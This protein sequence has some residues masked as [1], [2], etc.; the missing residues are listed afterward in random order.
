MDS[1][2]HHP[3]ISPLWLFVKAHPALWFFLFVGVVVLWLLN[4]LASLIPQIDVLRSKILLPIAKRWKQKKL[5]KSAI[6][7]DIRGHVNREV[8]KMK[9]YLPLDWI[10]EMDVDWVEAEGS[11]AQSNENK[12]VIRIRPVEDQDRNFANATYYYLRSCFFP[13]TQ[14][15]VPKAHYEA[16][17]L[18][19]CKKII[20]QRSQAALAFFEDSILE[21]SIQRHSSIPNH[22]DDYDRLDRRGFFTGTFL[23]ELHLMAVDARFT[24]ARNSMAQETALV[25]KHIKDFVS[26][27]DAYAVDKQEM[28]QSAWCNDEALSKYAILLVANPAKTGNGIDPYLN[29][30]RSRFESGS[31]RLYVFGS[32]KE[33]RFANSVIA[34]IEGTIDN[35]RL[36]ERFETPF[37][38]RGDKDGVGA[39]FEYKT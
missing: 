14:A 18:H 2:L 10:G 13:K 38:Y 15:V 4:A 29:R 11:T 5:A 32:N 26:A 6:K 20:M 37:D 24:G 23:R 12:I 30:A 19:V 21:P 27:Y 25:I 3:W 31:K 7:S 16:S 33:A 28:S 39:I 22:L 17:V 8:S 9:K 36:I 34:G 1:F 35:V